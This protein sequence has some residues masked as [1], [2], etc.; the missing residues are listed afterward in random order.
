M[1]LCLRNKKKY[2]SNTTGVTGVQLAVKP[3]KYGEPRSYYV[4]TWWRG[5]TQ[6]TASYSVEKFGDELAFK[7]ACYK[8]MIEMEYLISA[9]A[10]Y[11]L[12]H[13]L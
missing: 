1:K 9:G 8:R 2:K 13:G 3:R 11:T 7:L 6:H 10:G 4:A 12:T 5:D